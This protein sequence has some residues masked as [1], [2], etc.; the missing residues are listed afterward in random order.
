MQSPE[1]FASFAGH[2][3]KG[4]YGLQSGSQP[5]PGFYAIAPMYYRYEADTLRDK[6]GNKISPDSQDRGDLTANAYVFGLIWVSE[7]KI[8]GGNYSFQIYPGFTD[9]VL[10]APLFGLN[11]GV[12]T[13]FADLYFQPINLGWHTDRADFVTGLG[14]Y[15]PTGEYELGGSENRGLGMWTLE[16]FA[17][18]TVYLDDAKSWHAATTAFY[19]THSDKDG[20]DIRVGDILTLEGGLGKSFMDGTINVGASYYAQWKITED[21]FG[22]D[23]RTFSNRSDGKHSVY[24]VGPELTLALATS[25]KLYGVLNVRYFWEFDA[26]STFEGE[27]FLLTLTLPIPSVPLQ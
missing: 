27:T 14:V 3:T 12:S 1:V 24:G 21:S 13:G 6:D 19:E 25:E 15:A 10:E 17:G 20:T 26:E 5:A 16:F 9:N 11:E 7:Y 22:Q 23:G 2:N 18:S 8:F 4:D